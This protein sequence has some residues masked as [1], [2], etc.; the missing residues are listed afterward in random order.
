MFGL[1]GRCV[2]DFGCCCFCGGDYLGVGGG[3]GCCYG[4]AGCGCGR[5]VGGACAAGVLRVMIDVVDAVA[6]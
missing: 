2:S 6:L 3:L 1:A 4:G 5:G